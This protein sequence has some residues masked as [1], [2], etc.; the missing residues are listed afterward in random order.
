MPWF[1]KIIQQPKMA[2]QLMKTHNIFA[3]NITG[4]DPYREAFVIASHIVLQTKQRELNLENTGRT[5]YA[6]DYYGLL[7]INSRYFPTKLEAFF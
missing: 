2:K 1:Y 7:T 3:G 6:I 4:K 5:I